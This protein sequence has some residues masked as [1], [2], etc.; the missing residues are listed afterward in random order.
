MAS[1][2]RAQSA[3]KPAPDLRSLSRTGGFAQRRDGAPSGGVPRPRRRWVWRGVVPVLILL[4]LAALFAYTARAALMPGIPVQ[5][6]PVVASVGD[7]ADRETIGEDGMGSPASTP[8]RGAASNIQAPGWIEPAPYAITVPALADGTVAEVLALEGERVEAGQV[9]ARLV[10]DDAKLAVRAAEAAVMQAQ[11]GADGARA[12]LARA[13]ANA[14][15]DEA[16][17]SEVRDEVSRKRP[18]FEAGA[19]G[20]GELRRAELRLGALEARATAARRGAEAARSDVARADATLAAAQVALDEAR[21][22]FERMSIK[23]P[24][25]GVVLSRLVEPGARISMGS[26]GTDDGGAMAGAVLR[27]YDPEHLQVRVDVPLADSGKVP[28]DASAEITTEA[29][30]NLTLHGRVSRI[31]HEANIQRNTVQFK[32]EIENVSE[33]QGLLK[34]EMLAR[35]RF[36]SGSEAGAARAGSESGI[37]SVLVSSSALF[38]RSG[39]RARGWRVVPGGG[40]PRVELVELTV[41]EE[42]ERGYVLV[43]DGLRPSDRLVVDPP[44]SLRDGARVRILGEAPAMQEGEEE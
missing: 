24:A 17:A 10:D 21:L 29:L 31:V 27:L 34:P 1:T 4:A 5:V 20:A 26:R 36:T 40:G 6:T 15:A 23:S 13:E 16:L 3:D 35:V 32:V 12:A 39:D 9:V 30:P 19:V 8:G 14:V 37:G 28:R 33:A 41:G 2:H 7:A 38:D 43:H 25:S 11:A 18:L 44:R 22:R 42:P